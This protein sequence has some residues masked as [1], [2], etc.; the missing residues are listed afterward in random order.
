M[1]RRLATFDDPTTRDVRTPFSPLRGEGP[2]MSDGLISSQQ[3]IRNQI[4]NS[5]FK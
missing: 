1:V 2:G 4:V 3:T 5:E